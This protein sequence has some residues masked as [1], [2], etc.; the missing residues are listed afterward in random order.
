LNE[1]AWGNS[2]NRREGRGSNWRGQLLE[3]ASIPSD[4]KTRCW[5]GDKT[6][7]SC[8]KGDHPP[9][10]GM[11]RAQCCRIASSLLGGGGKKST[12]QIGEE[13]RNKTLPEGGVGKEALRLRRLRYRE[14]CERGSW[15]VTKSRRGLLNSSSA[16]G[17]KGWP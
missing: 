8:E 13:K 14:I 16:E 1:G 6:V 11:M 3:N 10:Y 2:E 5:G 17:D 9:R 12:I 15:V 7:H 4:P